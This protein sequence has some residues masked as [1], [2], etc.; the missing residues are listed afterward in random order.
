MSTTPLALILMPQC[1]RCG[2]T[3]SNTTSR[4]LKVHRLHCPKNKPMKFKDPSPRVPKLSK[5]VAQK[6]VE[7]TESKVILCILIP[8]FE[9]LILELI[10]Q[11]LE[12]PPHLEMDINMDALPLIPQDDGNRIFVEGSSVSFFYVILLVVIY[13][14]LILTFRIVRPLTS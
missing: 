14:F 9:R 10:F 6:H 12:T 1:N 13:G 2:A 11:I 8:I 4:A 3:L 7:E 5:N